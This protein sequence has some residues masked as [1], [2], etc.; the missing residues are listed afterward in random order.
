MRLNMPFDNESEDQLLIDRLGQLLSQTIK[1]LFPLN[2][3]P[4]KLV[5]PHVWRDRGYVGE[6]ADKIVAWRGVSANLVKVDFRYRAV[7]GDIVDNLL[8]VEKR[9]E[10]FGE[11]F[12]SAIA[13]MAR[14]VVLFVLDFPLD[15]EETIVEQGYVPRRMNRILHACELIDSREFLSTPVE[16]WVGRLVRLVMLQRLLSIHRKPLESDELSLQN[17]LYR[18]GYLHSY[19]VNGGLELHQLSSPR[20]AGDFGHDFH[21][22]VRNPALN[23]LDSF[24]MGVE[25]YTGAIGYHVQTIPKYVAHYQLRGIIVIAK[26]D[27][28]PFL[29]T[30]ASRFPLPIVKAR[31]LTTVGDQ[32]LV[33]IHYLPLSKIVGE[34]ISIRDQLEAV[35]PFV[36]SYSRKN[37]QAKI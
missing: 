19:I 14:F 1:T 3:E 11:P 5:K 20:K 28:M 36:R 6:H 17:L 32:N 18:T 33:A 37:V 25:V 34:F 13:D 16:H 24:S 22:I 21:A 23:A 26:D 9:I 2:V 27:P 30:N 10:L 29:L 8:P 31:S 15:A 35:I 12:A 4:E 7:Y